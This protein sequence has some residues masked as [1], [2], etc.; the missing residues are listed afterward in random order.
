MTKTPPKNRVVITPIINITK[1]KG[2]I[3]KI[4]RATTITLTTV[5]NTKIIKIKIS[6][7]MEPKNHRKLRNHKM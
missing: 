4:I 1:I 3:I 6:N 2:V 5:V 7:R